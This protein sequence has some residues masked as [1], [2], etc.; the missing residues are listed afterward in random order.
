MKRLAIAAVL[1]A[2]AA[3]VAWRA[4]QPV[5]A[6]TAMPPL[7]QWKRD[8]V[9]RVEIRRRDQGSIRLRKT[10][11]GWRVR[12]DG[13]EAPAD[14]TA[15]ARLLDDLHAMRPV[16]LVTRKAGHYRELGVD[17]AADR[18]RL[19]RADGTVVL[20]LFV[21][22]PGSDLVTTYVRPATQRAV[23]AVDKSLTWQVKRSPKAW[24]AVDKREVRRGDKG[25]G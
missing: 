17:E 4:G 21:G 7:P 24:R 9:E 1:L 8:A 13:K 12:M 15:V 20:D 2:L 3:G 5:G 16:R 14:A 23:L 11:K 18:I 10:A 25:E 22:K 19:V 6:P